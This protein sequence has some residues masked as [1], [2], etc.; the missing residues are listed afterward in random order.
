MTRKR[1]ATLPVKAGTL[2]KA[3]PTTARQDTIPPTSRQRI[4]QRIVCAAC[5]GLVPVS[6][7]EWLIARLRVRHD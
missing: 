6:W 7:A 1:K 2:G 3:A 5:W 4:K